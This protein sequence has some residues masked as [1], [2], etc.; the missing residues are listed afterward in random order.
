MLY[1]VY[2]QLFVKLIAS[3]FDLARLSASV[4]NTM[5]FRGSQAIRNLIKLAPRHGS[6]VIASKA[7]CSKLVASY[8]NI[9][10]YSSS[11]RIPL[12]A[13]TIN[14]L[15][16]R[17]FA[18]HHDDEGTLEEQTMDVLKLFDKVDPLKVYNY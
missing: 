7:P 6:R 12:P 13:F 18:D 1:A 10:A 8:T 5:A 9:A 16:R 4:K 17:N 11:S 14:L 3:N 15:T 2:Y